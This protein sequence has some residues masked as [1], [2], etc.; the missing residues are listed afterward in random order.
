MLSTF[1]LALGTSGAVLAAA[2][3]TVP[4]SDRA[5]DREA[6]AVYRKAGRIRAR[7]LLFARRIRRGRRGLQCPASAC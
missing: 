3:P 4:Q 5:A 7:P 2:P 1:L 6:I